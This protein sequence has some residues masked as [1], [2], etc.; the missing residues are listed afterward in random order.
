MLRSA[1]Q[2]RFTRIGM[3][4]III[5]PGIVAAQSG[6]E[7]SAPAVAPS[8]IEA[9]MESL[10]SDDPAVQI[11]QSALEAIAQASAAKNRTVDWRRMSEGAQAALAGIREALESPVPPV[12]VDIPPDASVAD[13]DAGLAETVASLDAA[14]YEA[15]ALAA[16]SQRRGQRSKDLPNLLSAAKQRLATA[17]ASMA[18]DALSDI[19]PGL[20]EARL[21]LAQ[22]QISEATAEIAALEAEQASYDATRDLLPAQRDL[23]ARRIME[24]E[25]EL[26][27]WQD[28]IAAAREREAR[29]AATEAERLRKQVSSNAPAIREYAEMNA[30]LAARLAAEAQIPATLRAA[31]GRL[32]VVERRL[33][34]I[35]RGYSAI[36][37]RLNASSPNRATGRML[38]K[39][40]KGL[41]DISTLER[42]LSVTEQL[43]EESEYALID[44]REA[45]DA[46]RSIDAEVSRLL[47]KAAADSDTDRASMETA[48]REIVIARR[49]LLDSLVSDASR[50]IQALVA[51]ERAE[52][53]L[54]EAQQAYRSFIRERILWVRSLPA[55]RWPGL[56][57][58]YELIRWAGD[59]TSWERTFHRS[60][61]WAMD[62]PHVPAAWLVAIVFAWI[63]AAFGP[64]RQADI[65]PRVRRHATDS[66]KLTFQ[67]LGWTMIVSLPVALVL[68]TLGIALYRPADQTDLGR[69]AGAACMGFGVV[70]AAFSF[71]RQVSCSNGLA[72]AHFRWAPSAASRLRRDARWAGLVVG[73]GAAMMAIADESGLEGAAATFGRFGFTVA[74]VAFGVFM[75][76]VLHSGGI[77]STALRE[78]GQRGWFRHVRS[79][80]LW[81]AVG[82][83]I[84]FVAL[85]W[86]GFVFT[87]YQLAWKLGVTFAFL[88]LVLVGNG[89]L[90]RWLFIARRRLAIEDARRRREDAAQQDNTIM[91][92][93]GAQDGIGGVEEDKID[94]PAISAQTERLIRIATVVAAWIGLFAIWGELMPALHILKRVELYP[95]LQMVDAA[96]IDTAAV[97][98][99]HSQR[100][101]YADVQSPEAPAADSAAP[102]PADT[103]QD[104]PRPVAPTML[105]G[106]VGQTDIPPVADRTVITLRDVLIACVLA[107]LTIVAF[108]N[109]P[110]LVE[111][112]ML[113]KLPFDA[114]VR[115]AV[116]TLLKYGIAI[117]GVLLTFGAIHVSWAK[118]QWLAAALTFGLAF[119]LQ[120]IF[121]NF[122]SGLI[123]L[124]ERPIRIGD[125]VTV[126]NITGTVTRIRM[127]ATTITD[128]DRKELV[129]PN[130]SFITGDVVNWTLSDPVLRLTI[131]VGI[132]YMGDVDKAESLLLSAAGEN[133]DVLDTP[134][135]YVHFGRFG[136]NS[137]EFELRVFIPHIDYLLSVRHA[138]HKRIIEMFREAEIEIAFP[139]R[140]IHIR[141]IDDTAGIVLKRDLN[142]SADKPTSTASQGE[143][144]PTASED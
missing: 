67:S 20:S 144:D 135:P 115:Y 110:G 32:T 97:L 49:E 92:P 42:Q 48:V 77:L 64:R 39:E 103:S 3:L 143:H 6:G 101:P 78:S 134:N 57:D 131:P 66:L 138:L 29:A 118:V 25:R 128:W 75:Y 121:A 7:S 36:R 136:D 124:A 56:G 99:T 132:S 106:Y 88:L 24:L 35:R 105:P 91:E 41:D 80:L 54:L 26:S 2:H 46:L 34:D 59:S 37:A 84:G 58:V 76:R 94:L 87:A 82:A 22:A 126:Q 52:R 117:L 111:M 112:L 16:E 113:Q 60:R 43:L 38:R 109:L 14:K 44:L 47:D 74:E 90:R 107:I 95:K 102:P 12:D 130:K 51:L 141:T 4:A 85:A 61:Q 53:Q 79:G 33:A 71:V 17:R 72:V 98:Q 21:V 119:G 28:A 63:G 123:I 23:A 70:W 18:A 40:Y 68:F 19:P 15:D 129:I 55:D 81:V 50:C 142:G 108:R 73:L 89:L 120:E 11:Y 1:L 62:R 116:T 30:S 5:L 133:P 114:G 127:R 86:V 83:P 65:A 45:R 31:Q 8:D 13:L 100:T 140:D 69:A 104:Q 137:L 9:R 96:D 27:V 122:V 125:T 10:P 93:I 139:Q